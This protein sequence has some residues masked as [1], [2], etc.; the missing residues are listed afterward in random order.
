KIKRSNYGEYRTHN[1][2]PGSREHK[3]IS[4][5][6]SSFN[7]HWK[8]ACNGVIIDITPVNRERFKLL[9]ASQN[10]KWRK[11][12]NIKVRAIKEP[13]ILED[14]NLSNYFEDKYHNLCALVS[15]PI[16]LLWSS[17]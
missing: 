1:L 3:I 2:R 10:S 8:I 11:L 5:I 7:N 17:K 15:D 6:K 16:P 9:R 12:A 14:L 13:Q 4:R